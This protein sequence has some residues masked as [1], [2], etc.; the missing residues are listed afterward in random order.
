MALDLVERPAAG[1]TRHIL[2]LLPGFGDEPAVFTDHLD[3][4][5]PDRRWHVAV[6]RPPL[7][8]AEGPAWFTVGDDGPDPDELAGSVAALA[9]VGAELLDRFGLRADELVLGG[10]SQ[11][12]AVAL[13]AALDPGFSPRP[14]AVAALAGYLPHRESR[15]DP[16]LAAGRPVLMAHGVD[17]DVVDALLGRSAAK[18]LHR[19]GAVVT[20]AEVASGHAVPG[21]IGDALRD[22]LA[23]LAEGTV[24]SDPPA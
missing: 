19:S 1:A 18:A 14:G 13:A 7:D 16:S 10:F 9:R 15:Q 12:G 17:D 20:W 23:A 24:P 8:T 4:I 5:D 22:W 2:L 3:S 6:A 11:G 21:P